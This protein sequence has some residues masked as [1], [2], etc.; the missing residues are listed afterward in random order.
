MKTNA[1]CGVNN[2]V[3]HAWVNESTTHGICVN[4]FNC[5]APLRQPIRSY[6][7][8]VTV[9]TRPS[10]NNDLLAV[11]TAKHGAC[12]MSNGKPSTVDK[13]LLMIVAH[14]R[15]CSCISELHLLRR[16]DSYHSLSVRPVQL[17]T[18]AITRARRQPPLLLCLYG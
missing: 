8:I 4:Y 1:V 13:D 12:S 7:P 15:K 18:N 2:N 6:S 5:C 14:C 10:N 17:H 11:R 3:C 9:V 16:E